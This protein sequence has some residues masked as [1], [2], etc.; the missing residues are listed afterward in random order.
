MAEYRMPSLGA[1]MKDGRVVEWHVRA[2]DP[3]RRG[4]VVGVVDTSKG[5]IEVEIWEDGVVEEIVVPPGEKVPVGE[6][7]FRYSAADQAEAPPGR[8]A[9]AAEAPGAEPVEPGTEAGEEVATAGPSADDRRRP[10][11][12]APGVRRSA[13]V[14][15]ASPVARKRARELGVDLSGIRGSGPGGAV[16][17]ADVVERADA[18]EGEAAAA[19]EGRWPSG[20]PHATPLARKAAEIHGVELAALRGTGPGGLITRGDV[21]GATGPAEPGDEGHGPREALA[22]MRSAIAA[23]M[24]RSKREIPHYYLG[25]T[26]SLRRA[27]AW[28]EARNRERPPEERILQVALVLKAVA[29]AVGDFPEMNGHWVDGT[30]RPADAV[31]PGLAVSLRGGGLVA[32]AIHDADQQTPEALTSVVTELVQ[33][34]RVGRLRSSEVTDATL[35]LSS[36]GDRGVESLYGVIYPPQVALVG[37]GRT[38]ERPWAEEGMLGV[39]PVARITLSGDH[40]ASD[41]HRGGLFLERIGELLQSPEEL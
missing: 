5:A 28:L 36:L 10:P 20:E 4:D 25:T 41:G 15:R 40:R 33:R 38:V 26:V 37:V 13:D 24:A 27:R 29:V 14:V 21:E 22:S 19:D 8:G 34:A 1:D 16:V 31:H 9:G 35:T 32:P 3:V 11:E 23:A 17:L 39:H 2:G 30:F 18:G 12:T 7:L 6:V